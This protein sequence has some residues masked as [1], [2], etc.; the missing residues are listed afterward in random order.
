VNATKICEKK[1]K[2]NKYVI[3]YDPV[4]LAFNFYWEWAVGVGGGIEAGLQ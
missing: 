1:K 3:K 2:I 4:T